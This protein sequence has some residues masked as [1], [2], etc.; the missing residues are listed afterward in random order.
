MSEE[1][2]RLIEAQGKAH[3]DFEKTANEARAK[4]AQSIEELRGEHSEYAEKMDAQLKDFDDYKNKVDEL[5]AQNEREALAGKDAEKNAAEITEFWN[6]A[7]QGERAA[8]N[9]MEVRSDPDGGYTV[10]QE[11]AARIIKSS[12]G[13]NP[14]AQLAERA[15][16]SGNSL[17]IYADPDELG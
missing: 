9:V 5:H 15:T 14:M 2:K 7:R 3:A 8:M 6:I 13:N 10:P 11:V 4:N 1:L 12:E 17:D 16:I